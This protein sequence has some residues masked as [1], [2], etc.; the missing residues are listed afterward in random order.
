VGYGTEY[1]R[2]LVATGGGGEFA[3]MDNWQRLVEIVVSLNKDR[4]KLGRLTAAAAASG[5]LLDRDIAM[6]KRIDLIKQHLPA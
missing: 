3:D 6:Q 1:P 4:R 5:N 2:E